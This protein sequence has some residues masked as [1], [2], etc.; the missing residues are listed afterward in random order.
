MAAKS[1]LVDD[2]FVDYT[3]Q[4]IG[5]YKNIVEGERD[6]E[7]CSDDNIAAYIMIFPYHG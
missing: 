3:T 5:D 1:L 2:Q 6:F 7:H 4:Y